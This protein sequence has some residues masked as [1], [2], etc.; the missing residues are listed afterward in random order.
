MLLCVG[1]G[2]AHTLESSQM[3]MLHVTYVNEDRETAPSQVYQHS[4]PTEGLPEIPQQLGFSKFSSD[5]TKPSLLLTVTSGKENSHFWQ[6]LLFMS[7]MYNLRTL[8]MRH[9]LHK[10][11]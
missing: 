7:L 1:G 6:C 9:Y 10:Q 11:Q 3:A 2:G 8:A 5:R 4:H